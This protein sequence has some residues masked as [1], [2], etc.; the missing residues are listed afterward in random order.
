MHPLSETL[1]LN[2]DCGDLLSL[3]QREFTSFYAAV[4]TLFGAETARAAADQWLQELAR[5][6]M[7]GSIARECRAITIRVAA[8]MN[9]SMRAA[10]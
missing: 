2:S 9:V 10:A 1:W 7:K 8:S 3:A 4:K 5:A 6:S